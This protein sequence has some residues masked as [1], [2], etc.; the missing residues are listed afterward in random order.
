LLIT[1]FFI[2]YLYLSWFDSK[3]LFA[4]ARYSLRYSFLAS[5]KKMPLFAIARY[6]K[7]CAEGRHLTRHARARHTVAIRAPPTCPPGGRL[8]EL[9]RRLPELSRRLPESSRLPTTPFK[10]EIPAGHRGPAPSTTF[11]VCWRKIRTL[12]QAHSKLNKLA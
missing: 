11:A 10:A 9:S 2:Y 1:L 8:P 12:R 3:S 4:I 6:L 5:E 7:L